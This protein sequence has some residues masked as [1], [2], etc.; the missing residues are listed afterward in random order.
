MIRRLI[1]IAVVLVVAGGV[2]HFLQAQEGSTR[3]DW[4]GWRIEGPTS[5]VVVIL[6]M[7]IGLAVGLDRLLGYL[8]TLPSRIFSGLSQRRHQHGHD[9]LALGLMA[10][11]SDNRRDAARHAKQA[12]RLLGTSRLTQ[13]LSAQAANLNGNA[14]VARRFFQTLA[15]DDDLDLAFLGLVELTSLEIENGNDEAALKAARQAFGLNK[16]TPALG[17]TLFTLEA[18]FGNWQEAI[19]ALNIAR[20]DPEIDK[21]AVSRAFATAYYNLAS[22]DQMTGLKNLNLALKHDGGFVPAVLAA[23]EHYLVLGDAKKQ[24]SVLQGGFIRTPHPEIA[25]AFIK[26]GQQEP[27]DNGVATKALGRLIG[28]AEK[29]DDRAN[30]LTCVARLAMT[31]ELFGEALRLVMLIA[32]DDRNQAAWLVLADLAAEKTDA[33][34]DM[35]QIEA[36]ARAASAPPPPKWWSSSS[37]EISAT[38]RQTC[39]TFDGL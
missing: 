35:S 32:E 28:L 38:W 19:T 4:L 1:W 14:G 36:Y 3:I 10:L 11:S 15:N 30:A 25:E 2:A 18:R 8:A 34:L 24:Q 12:Q 20:H 31:L 7:L 17:K 21:A 27:Q 23:S 13:L 39:Q 33:W 37:E 16:N 6:I 29:H 26:A 9:V 5:L 22:Q